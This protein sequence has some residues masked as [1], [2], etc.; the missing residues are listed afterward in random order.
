MQGNLWFESIKPHRFCWCSLNHILGIIDSMDL[1]SI[2]QFGTHISS[3][4]NLLELQLMYWSQLYESFACAHCKLL[5]AVNI[6]I[7]ENVFGKSQLKDPWQAA[8][9]PCSSATL[10]KQHQKFDASHTRCYHGRSRRGEMIKFAR[11]Q[12]AFCH[13]W[14][15]RSKWHG[16]GYYTP[17]WFLISILQN[18]IISI[19]IYRNVIS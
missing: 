9:V 3:S 15:G 5:N 8:E 14:K 6:C 7:T 19:S 12:L 1:Q 13:T 10:A 11:S 18:C 4:S 16:K 17:V 2:H